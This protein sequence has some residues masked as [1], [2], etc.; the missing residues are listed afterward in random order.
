MY[1]GVNFNQE[2]TTQPAEHFTPGNM[3]E[4]TY[5]GFDVS[6]TT[7]PAPNVPGATLCWSIRPDPSGLLA[8]HYDA[9]LRAIAANHPAGAVLSCWHEA[10]LAGISYQSA[11]KMQQHCHQIVHSVT[12]TLP[13]INITLSGDATK[14][15]AKGMDGYAVDVYDWN[16]DGDIIR[17]LDYW[18]NRKDTSGFRVRQTAPTL[19]TETNSHIDAHRPAWFR[20]GYN[21]LASP[22]AGMA[23]MQFW[24][25][26]GK[27]SGSFSTAGPATIAML[28]Q[29]NANA[30]TNTYAV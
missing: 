28:N 5:A 27:W 24:L 8:G 26:G 4:R 23:M 16:S 22:P 17:H 29:I 20:D 2:H 19:I 3:M 14:W 13:F 18:Y 9:A 11:V 10:S 21:W 15:D 30:P 12:N 25:T 7:W 1:W 6:T